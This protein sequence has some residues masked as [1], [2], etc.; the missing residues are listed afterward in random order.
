MLLEV[1][2]RIFINGQ[3][4]PMEIH[5]RICLYKTPILGLMDRGLAMH[6]ECTILL[7]VMR[8]ARKQDHEPHTKRPGVRRIQSLFVF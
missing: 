5:I 2:A 6:Y 1:L 4:R 8:L 3:S 7:E